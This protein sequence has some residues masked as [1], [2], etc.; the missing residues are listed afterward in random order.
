M[1]NSNS[2]QMCRYELPTCLLEVWGDR[3]ALSEWTD[4]PVVMNLKWRLR[5]AEK[6]LKGNQ[7]QLETLVDSI[8]D[9]V[10]DLLAKDQTPKSTHALR[11]PQLTRLNLTTLQLFD[12]CTSLEL[13]A[14]E[15]AILPSLELEVKRITPAWLKIAAV[16]VATVGVTTSAVRL[17]SPQMSSQ[18]ASN[19]SA[20]TSRSPSSP[21]NPLPTKP[22]VETLLPPAT[23]I[24]VAPLPNLNQQSREVETANILGTDK[25]GIPSLPAIAQTRPAPVVIAKRSAA[26]QPA[27][28]PANKLARRDESQEVKIAD[29]LDSSS[30]SQD[31]IS[32]NRSANAQ[33]VPETAPAI[34]SSPASRQTPAQLGKVEPSSGVSSEITVYARV[35][36]TD[37]KTSIKTSID[38][39][40]TSSLNQNLSALR[41]P[42]GSKGEV[43]LELVIERGR[44]A[45]ITFDAR[46]SSLKDSD[47]VD[48][49][50]RSLQTWTPPTPA[51]GTIHIV[52]QVSP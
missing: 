44:I 25:N 17:I 22:K 26:N 31:A 40:L 48:L 3:S 11:L 7:V 18:I 43:L 19:P 42:K 4:R 8:E 9:Y 1:I 24:T 28:K 49:I 34:I 5:I 6:S 51:N 37:V 35:Q 12:L 29:G 39:D 13:C 14:N 15:I 52:L 2:L 45:R 36:V 30:P 10:K 50:K 47:T 46:S 20:N 41:L 33:L 38:G 27:N 21:D 32:S 16:L 23:G